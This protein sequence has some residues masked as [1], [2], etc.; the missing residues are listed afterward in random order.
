[1]A[2]MLLDV[3]GTVVTDCVSE[4]AM[5]L[6]PKASEKLCSPS[7]LVSVSHNFHG[8]NDPWQSFTFNAVASIWF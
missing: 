3:M 6:V 7:G 5:I 4:S 2:M 1:M 8:R